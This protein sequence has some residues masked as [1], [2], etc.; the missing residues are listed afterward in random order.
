MQTRGA[1]DD[2][3]LPMTE[4]T[5]RYTSRFTEF[6]IR[7]GEAVPN[8]DA[9]RFRSDAMRVADAEPIPMMISAQRCWLVRRQ[10]T[11]TDIWRT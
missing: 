5:V 9:D 8:N 10:L 2:T 6:Q 11:S 1:Y 3:V 4:L 7:A